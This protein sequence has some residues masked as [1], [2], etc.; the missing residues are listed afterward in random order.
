ME[1]TGGSLVHAG[2]VRHWWWLDRSYYP[3]YAECEGEPRLAV[4]GCQAAFV[5]DH[6]Y[7]YSSRRGRTLEYEV[8]PSR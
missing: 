3:V 4:E 6:A 1:L 2:H 5:A 8:E 7:G